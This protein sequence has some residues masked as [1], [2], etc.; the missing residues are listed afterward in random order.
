LAKF[1]ALLP[2]NA[3]ILD[4]GCGTGEPIARYFIEKGY[5]LTGVDYA[6]SMIRLVKQRFPEQS[7]QVADM[8]ELN[9]GRRFG[10]LLGWHSFF[11]LTRDEQRAVLPLFSGHLNPGGV[12]MLT[13]G[14]KEGEWGGHVA[15]EDVYQASLSPDEYRRILENLNFK[16]DQFVAE[17]PDCGYATIILSRKR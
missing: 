9:L 17:D 7:W 11:H 5:D 10:G 6:Q 3:S 13:V 2:A 15:G 12:M 1:E 8:R 16:I 4:V 14:P